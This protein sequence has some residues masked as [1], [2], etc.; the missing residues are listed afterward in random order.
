[1]ADQEYNGWKNYETWC[2][3]L[4]LTN[5]EGSDRYWRERGQEARQPANWS[6]DRREWVERGTFT[7]DETA[8]AVLAEWLKDETEEAAQDLLEGAKASA[9]TVGRSTQ[10]R[11]G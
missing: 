5:E 10:L 11:L 4:W 7:A 3:N 1:M 8:A 6:S 2:V 9:S